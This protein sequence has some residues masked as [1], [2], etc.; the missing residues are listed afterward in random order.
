MADNPLLEETEIP[1]R[2]L[3]A[4]PAFRRVVVVRERLGEHRGYRWSRRARRTG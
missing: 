4:C 1:A 2:C 3:A